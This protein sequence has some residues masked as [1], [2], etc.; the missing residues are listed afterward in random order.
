M[1]YRRTAV[2]L[3]LAA[4]LTAACGPSGP[5]RTPEV[6]RDTSS[7]Q[8][9]TAQARPSATPTGPTRTPT[10]TSTPYSRPTDEPALDLSLPIARVGNHEI[11]LGDF[12][13]RVRYERFAALEEI[14]L[15][16]EQ[17]GFE[18]VNL[19]TSAENPAADRVAS[20]FS[21]LAN[22]RAFG[23][24]IYD[25]L[26]REAVIRDEAA[27]RNLEV[28]QEDIDGYW[29]RRFNLQRAANPSD[30]LKPV[31]D[32]YMARAESYSGMDQAGINRI[33]ESFV[34]ASLLEPIIAR[35][36]MPEPQIATFRA[37]RLIAATQADAESAK[38]LIEAGASFRTAVCRY[39]IE[40][41]ARGNG[42]DLGFRSRRD[43]PAGLSN[44]SAVIDAES[45]TV[46]A[47]QLSPVGWYIFRVGEK[48]RDADGETQAQVAAILVNSESLS[49]EIYERIQNGEDFASLACEYSLDS[50][51]G[52]GG[53]L[54]FIALEDLAAEWSPVLISET[55]TGLYGVVQTALGYELVEVSERKL[56]IPQPSDF[57]RAQDKAFADWQASQLAS[58][59]V[60]GLSDAWREAIPEDPLPRQV[61]PFL[62]E[63][64]FGLP[65]LIPTGTGTPRS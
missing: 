28:K 31:L 24:Q 53:D 40:A 17:V 30:A 37:R 6:I 7:Q 62:V 3:L 11:T 26:L 52:T 63:E 47:P 43:L 65:T 55:G 32:A 19:A 59:R 16:V 4:L 49:K 23:F 54:G 44:P 34:Q 33:A 56:E 22:S 35:E 13:A 12:R 25:V 20:I 48:R 51:G 38:A 10:Q 27:K 64:N 60:Q 42:G 18:P 45:G 57:E 46:L 5:A 58:S 36:T 61:A 41:A 9:L 50:S 1:S 8:T 21:T 29:I 15:F 2:L 14:R 39:S